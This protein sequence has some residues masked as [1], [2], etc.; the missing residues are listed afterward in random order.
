MGDGVSSSSTFA[1]SLMNPV[2]NARI[3]MHREVYKAAEHGSVDVLRQHN[4]WKQEKT[5]RENNVLH[6]HLGKPLQKNRRGVVIDHVCMS[7]IQYVVDETTEDSMLLQ[8]NDNG[9]TP[10]HL[11]A[12]FGHRAVVTEF[13]TL[14]EVVNAG[15]LN[16]A[17]KRK[18]TALHDAAR[19]GH[20][21]IVMML[22]EAG[23]ENAL[24]YM[25]NNLLETPVFLAAERGCFESF[26]SIVEH[27][28]LTVLE[29]KGPCGQTALHLAVLCGN[30]D[31]VERILNIETSSLLIRVKNDQGQTPLHSCAARNVNEQLMILTA[32]LDHDEEYN[33]AVYVKDNDGRT[34]LHIA[35]LNLNF[36][37]AQMLIGSYPDCIEMVDNK[38]WNLVHFAA[39][40]GCIAIIEHLLREVPKCDRLINEKDNDGNTPLHLLVAT[41][42][43]LPMNNFFLK[44]PMFV[45]RNKNLDVMAFN[46]KNFTAGNIMVSNAGVPRNKLR[47][48]NKLL[49][50][51]R[52]IPNIAEDAGSI[53]TIGSV[54]NSEGKPK[55]IQERI[56][57]LQKVGETRLV[58][59][60]LIATVSFTA[61]FTLPGG[62]DQ[63]PGE[64]IGLAV[65][66]KKAS[67]IV[68]LISNTIAF[69]LS[70]LAVICYFV[71]PTQTRL[72][73]AKSVSDYAYVLS[74]VS[75]GALMIAF[76]TGVYAV[77]SQSTALG[78]I[79]IAI[80]LFY[81]FWYCFLLVKSFKAVWKTYI[82]GVKR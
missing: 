76:V 37:G 70:S 52:R 13:L 18:D 78:L 6:V 46:D 50:K 15:L 58:V 74:T 44:L 27:T 42:P 26:N 10:L 59:A 56:D 32:L 60:A 57:Y 65:L 12:R 55:K 33:S 14:S 53:N 9:D 3:G 62:F 71:L 47:K 63:S 48:L 16:K 11:A 72:M 5:S 73:G 43:T 23:G 80:S 28:D 17:N 51:G 7:F 30:I 20:A 68:F 35:T 36:N 34:A 24:Q 49:P 4:N 22:V 29:H 8:S 54:E 64:T 77:V 19:A 38:G 81:F 67:F 79:I 75:M 31:I 66:V 2:S 82:A 1:T 41:S 40:S 39:N 45:R 61:G 69:T 25:P 21:D